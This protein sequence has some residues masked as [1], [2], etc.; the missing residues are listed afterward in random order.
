M[1]LVR[2][3]LART[4]RN[5]RLAYAGAIA[6]IVALAFGIGFFDVVRGATDLGRDV[7]S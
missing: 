5:A 6:A 1:A 4:Q 7:L 2:A 3:D